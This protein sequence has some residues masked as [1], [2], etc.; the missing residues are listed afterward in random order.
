MIKRI[1]AFCLCLCLVFCLSACKKDRFKEEETIT[2]TVENSTTQEQTPSGEENP[3]E[4]PQNDNTA[5]DTSNDK[6]YPIKIVSTKQ[7]ESYEINECFE[8]AAKIYTQIYYNCVPVDWDLGPK[9]IKK[10][11]SSNVY[12]RVSDSRFDSVAELEKYLNDFFTPE[13]IKTFYNPANFVD[14]EGHLYAISGTGSDDSLLAGCVFKV[15]KQTTM[16]VFFTADVYTYKKIE[17][18]PQNSEI[19][20]E[21][22]KDAS[23][24][25]I[26]SVEYVYEIAEDKQNWKFSKFGNII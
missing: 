7:L 6:S 18:K 9:Q 12:F 15:T 17:D 24:F 2:P 20:T 19:F 11:G 25:N 26:K 1:L 13:C 10:D 21:A 3:Q 8:K 4:T 16:R 23:L 22:P 5:V 14:Y